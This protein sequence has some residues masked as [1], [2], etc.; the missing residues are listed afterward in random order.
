MAYHEVVFPRRGLWVR[1]VGRVA[2]VVDPGRVHF[3]ARGSAHRVSHPAGCGDENLGIALDDRALAAIAPRVA[4]SGTVAALAVPS[5]DRLHAELVGLAI[6][7]NPSAERSVLELEERALA[8]V[9]EAFASFGDVTEL[10]LPV[11]SR[12]EVAEEARIILGSRFDEPM[13]LD[14]LARTLDV[15]PFH[16]SRVFREKY[17]TSLHAFRNSLRIRAALELLPD[18]H[19][20]LEDIAARTGF[21]GRSQLSRAM[22]RATGRPPERWRREYAQESS[23]GA[24][25]RA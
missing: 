8:V 16:M 21:G 5:T 7:L 24:R 13:T 2:C 25:P 19:L 9:R 20:A 22:R 1:H 14:D 15:S 10:E 11:K 17:G 6:A 23:R 12:R 4:E 18:S 3:F